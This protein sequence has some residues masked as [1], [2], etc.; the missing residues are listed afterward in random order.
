MLRK[1]R[2]EHM[3]FLDKLPE[4]GLVP[5]GKRWS[6]ANSRVG[7]GVLRTRGPLGKETKHVVLPDGERIAHLVDVLE[8][9]IDARHAA[10]GAGDVVE[11][12]LDDVGQD[13]ELGH[14]RGGGAAQVVQRPI[15]VLDSSGGSAL[16]RKAS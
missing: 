10:E 1:A 15:Q 9:V 2:S 14:A 13:A 8:A 16:Q 11:D 4:P 6:S 7:R 5:G 12:A 3:R